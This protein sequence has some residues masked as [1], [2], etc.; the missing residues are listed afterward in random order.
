MRPKSPRTDNLL[1]QIL[2]GLDVVRGPD[3]RGEYTAWC[4]FHPDGKG[5]LPHKANLNV[6]KRGFTCH[7]CGEKGSLRV[8]AE[9]LGIAAGS[10]VTEPTHVY[11]Y[12]DE[13]GILLFQV[14]RWPGKRFSQRRPD[15][16]DGWIWN[17]N[18]IRRVL[19]RL[20]EIIA[21]PDD[22]VFVCL[23][24]PAGPM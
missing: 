5:K 10:E 2:E 17:L 13:Q 3:A 18:G 20:P 12:R 23:S 19:Y 22:L 1:Q 7:A 4:P 15:G 9:K 11:D 14:V 8:L 6:S 24:P 16:K 21:R